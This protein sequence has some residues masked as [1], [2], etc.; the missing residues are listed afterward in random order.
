MKNFV[1]L[2][3][4]ERSGSNFIVSLMNGHPR[5]SGPPPSHLFRLFAGNVSNYGELTRQANWETLVDDCIA[6]FNAKLGQW[7]TTSSRDEIIRSADT[8]TAAEVLRLIYEKE[9]VF[10]GATHIFVK[11][12]HTDRFVSYLRTNF[13]GCRFVWLVRDP[14][15]VAASWVRTRGI[16]GGVENAIT[17]WT[18]DQDGA[19]RVFDQLKDSGTILRVHY[20]DLITNTQQTLEKLVSFLDLSYDERMLSFFREPRTAANAN[21][22]EAWANLSRP[23]LCGNSG[24]YRQVLTQEDQRFTE[25]ACGPLMEPLGYACETKITGLS[26][27][28]RAIEMDALRPLL[29]PGGYEIRD[30]EEQAI[31][32]RRQAAIETVLKRRLTP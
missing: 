17:A 2:I 28:R 5:I 27:R 6:A 16:P 29:S 32:T 18:G 25:L 12:N 30:A 15:D 7:S 14:R 22:I 26:T 4:T 10:D 23:I 31:R 13:P 20:E 1:F 21:R 3:S 8:R 24:N 19:Q 9:A 11:E